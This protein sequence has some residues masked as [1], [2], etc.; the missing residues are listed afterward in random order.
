MFASYSDRW[1]PENPN[2]EMIR[3]KAQGSEVYSSLYVEDGS[4]LKLK[5][6]TLGYTFSKEALKKC[7]L[8]NARI[9]VAAENIFTLSKYSGFVPEVSV[10]HSVLTPGFDWSSYPRSFNASVGLNLTF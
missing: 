4:Y 9:F 2:N 10:R 7:H 5:S 3:A 8:A 1:T 6:V